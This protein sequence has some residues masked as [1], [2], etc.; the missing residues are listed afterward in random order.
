VGGGK[1]RGRYLIG[2]IMLDPQTTATLSQ[3]RAS[4]RSDSVPIR[5]RVD[6]STHRVAALQ[7]QVQALEEHKAMMEEA[8]R[9]ER[10]FQTQRF[11]ALAQYVA[12][13]GLTMGRPAPPELFAPPP[14]P[15][16]PYVSSTSLTKRLYCACRTSCR[17][18]VMGCLR[19][20]DIYVSRPSCR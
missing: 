16:P 2:N 19:A 7:A 12:S 13:L 5:P 3:V 14:Y 15:Q 17:S 4:S 20:I 6:T 11:D 18:Y 8:Q 9:R 1:K 10:E